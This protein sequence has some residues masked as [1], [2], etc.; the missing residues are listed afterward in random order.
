MA[1]APINDA[2]VVGGGLVSPVWWR[3]LV[4]KIG[5]RT[6]LMQMRMVGEDGRITAPWAA[7]L[8]APGRPPAPLNALVLGADDRI[9]REW[10]AWLNRI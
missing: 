2:V 7:A 6:A 10:L 3:Y 9:S 5:T 8:W 1:Y 4:D